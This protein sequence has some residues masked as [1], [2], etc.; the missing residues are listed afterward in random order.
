MDNHA[1]NFNVED[2]KWL[3]GIIDSDGCV[4]I[5][6]SKR[7]NSKIVYTPSICITNCNV[8]IIETVHYLL[9]YYNINHHIKANGTCK[10]IVISRPNVI[11]NFC[12][13]MSNT[14]LVKAKEF[15][16]IKAFCLSRIENVR[17]NGCN[18]KACYTDAEISIANKLSYL[19]L[20][21]YRECIEYGIS[22][23]IIDY[24]ILNLFSLG[25]LAGFI[26]GDGCI[27][28]NKMK[29][30]SGKYQ[31]Q[32]LISIVTGSPLCKNI[33]SIYL[34]RYNINYYMKKELPGTTHKS[35]CI[36]KKF[37][38]S[39]RSLESCIM[40]SNLLKNKLY[41]KRD[42]CLDLINF[43]NSRFINKNKPYNDYEISLHDHI[44]NDIRDSSTTKSRTSYDEDIV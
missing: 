21:H 38:F 22:E 13:L 28:I 3:G 17:L 16:F 30:P 11:V 26:D 42:R 24:D 4:S 35:N 19:N 32:P 12:E 25:W 1:G 10:N 31:Y 37:E 18:W 29:R 23:N 14:I 36:N 8:I 20:N 5:S 33:L 7:K 41:G 27:T 40:I 15:L 34:D 44:K 9:N 43:C 39:I 6:K 2:L